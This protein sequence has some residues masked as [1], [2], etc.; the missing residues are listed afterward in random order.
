MAHGLH[1][2]LSFLMEDVHATAQINSVQNWY[3]QVLFLE[4][5]LYK[6]LD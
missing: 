4:I 1:D 3:S 2:L 5:D 6:V